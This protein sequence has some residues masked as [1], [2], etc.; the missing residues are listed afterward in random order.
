MT[1]YAAIFCKKTVRQI[2]E[3]LDMFKL[4]K[5]VFRALSDA[6][7]LRLGFGSKKSV[8]VYIFQKGSN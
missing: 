1:K 5:S 4:R 8:F 6:H 3:V 2:F 7:S